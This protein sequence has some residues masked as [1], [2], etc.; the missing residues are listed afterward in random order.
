MKTLSNPLKCLFLLLIFSQCT[1]AD[2]FKKTTTVPLVIAYYSGD[3]TS[4]QQFDLNGVD[5]LIY[6]FLH[7]KGN[8]LAIDN[9]KDSISLMQLT[10]LKTKYPELKVLVSL[11]GW[12]GCETCSDVFN[13][14]E[15]R[16][17]FAQSTAAIIEHYN[18]DGIDLDWEYPV[19]S[20]YPGHTYREADKDNFSALVQELRK[21]MQTNDILS[22]AAGGFPSF[23][24]QSIDWKRVMPLIDHVNVMSYDMVGGFSKK[25]GHHTPLFS[26]PNQIRSADQAIQYLKSIGVPS[27]KI[28]IGAAFYGRIFENVPPANNGLYQPGNFKRGVNQVQFDEVTKNFEFFWDDIAQAPYA[29]DAENQLFLTYDNERS[30]ALKTKYAKKENLG[31]IMFWQLRNDKPKNGLLKVM[32]KSVKGD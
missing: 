26:T 22:F 7:L 1:S 29:Y 17:E 25:T 8:Q 30:I 13:T 31:G 9:A 11:G 23:L 5:Q 19:I 15:G 32:V 3:G 14:E 27:S 6:S 21:V 2:A 20:G 28:V 16:I 10:G 12:G 18:A 4:I 24:E